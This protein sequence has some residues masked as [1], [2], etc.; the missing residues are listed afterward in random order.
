MPTLQVN[1]QGA[2]VGARSLATTA[3]GWTFYRGTRKTVRDRGQGLGKAIALAMAH[4]GAHVADDDMGDI[5][6]D[7]LAD[8]AKELEAIGGQCLANPLR[9]G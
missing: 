1:Y 5:N 8:A 3:L 7:T 4:E 6:Q 9:K 2:L